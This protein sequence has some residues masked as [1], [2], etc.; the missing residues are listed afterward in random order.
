[1]TNAQ[2]VDVTPSARTDDD[3][4]RILAV[5]AT[6]EAQTPAALIKIMASFI[7]PAALSMFI[8]ARTQ[9]HGADMD[10]EHG[11]E[12]AGAATYGFILGAAFAAAKDAERAPKGRAGM[13][14]YL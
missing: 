14:G 10:S 2:A 3:V 11:Q 7:D 9:A 6:I 4:A 13:G 5:D 1:M 8:G 12:L